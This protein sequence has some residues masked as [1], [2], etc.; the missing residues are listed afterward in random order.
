MADQDAVAVWAAEVL[1]DIKH[2]THTA[3]EPP[4]QP[5]ELAPPEDSAAPSTISAGPAAPQL[6]LSDHASAPVLAPVSALPGPPDPPA[7]ST[8]S[9]A[10]AHHAATEFED[11]DGDVEMHDVDDPP[12]PSSLTASDNNETVADGEVSA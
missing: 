8:T 11:G 6:V 5:E 2:E 7:S 12:T 9:V 3:G 4:H 1:M 10:A